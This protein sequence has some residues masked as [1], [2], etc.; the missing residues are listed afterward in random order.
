MKRLTTVIVCAVLLALVLLVS[1]VYA[2]AA[3]CGA[4]LLGLALAASAGSA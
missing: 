1:G 4:V 3:A 2:I